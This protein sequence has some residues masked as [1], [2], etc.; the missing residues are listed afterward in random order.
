MSLDLILTAS[1]QPRFH[2]GDV[3]IVIS[4]SV[5]SFASFLGLLGS[6]LNTGPLSG[7]HGPRPFPLAPSTTPG[8]SKLPVL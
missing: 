1:A 8:I 2:P 5:G 3:I 6:C 7:Y 4:V